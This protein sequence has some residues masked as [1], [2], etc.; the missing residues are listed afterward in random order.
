MDAG[1]GLGQSIPLGIHDSVLTE[2]GADVISGHTWHTMGKF[3]MECLFVTH[4][5]TEGVSTQITYGSGPT[6]TTVLMRRKNQDSLINKKHTVK[7][8]IPTKVT[9]CIKQDDQRTEFALYA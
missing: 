5:I 7:M 3:P 8:V 1:D 6:R 2:S 9:H 4:A